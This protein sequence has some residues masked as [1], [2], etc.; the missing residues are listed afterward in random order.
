MAGS[1]TW[2]ESRRWI[3]RA[4]YKTVH[5]S[6]IG[7]VTLAA[8]NVPIRIGNATVM[9]GDVAIGDREGVTFV[10]PQRWNGSSTGPIDARSR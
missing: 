8:V 4:Y 5:P 2:M 3:C 10:P 9:P 6:A 1:A 7:G